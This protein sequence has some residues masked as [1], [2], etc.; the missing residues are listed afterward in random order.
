MSTATIEWSGKTVTVSFEDSFVLEDH[1]RV[2][3]HEMLDRAIYACGFARKD[4]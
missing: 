1:E 4:E 3:L 2:D